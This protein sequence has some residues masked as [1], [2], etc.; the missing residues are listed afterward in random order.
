MPRLGE[1]DLIRQLFAPL[2]RGAAGAYNLTDD[3]AS[4][5]PSHGCEVVV[6]KDALV[7]GVHFFGDD[8]ADL[9]ARKSLRV[10]LSDLA[11][12]GAKPLGFFMALALPDAADD[13]WIRKFAEGLGKDIDAFE[14][15]LFGGDTVSTPG[16][17]MVSITA[18]GEV[19]QG[20]MVRRS[21]AMPGDILCVSGTIGDAAL[22]LDVLK[23]AYEPLGAEHKSFLVDRYRLPQPR[24]T[25][26]RR[27]AARDSACLDISDG[28]VADVGHIC[29]AS[30]V[31]VEIDAEKVPLSVAARAVLS[32]DAQSLTRILTG[33]DDYELAFAVPPANLAAA[34]SY[35]QACGVAVTEIGRFTE[36]SG[37]TVLG[38]HGRPLALSSGGYSHR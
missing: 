36:G 32:S 33:G 25:L 10:N 37:V 7:A 13:D 14:C 12:K 17:A 20:Q 11:A 3:A 31:G 16:P 35:G 22:G 2:T 23:G 6:T 26:G 1:F 18:F 5:S 34:R 15:P 9:I 19:K 27:E 8:P 29:E 28:L 21:G 38:G 4:I 24:L 30:G